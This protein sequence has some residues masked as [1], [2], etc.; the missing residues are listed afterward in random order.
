MQKKE[1]AKGQLADGD[2][3]PDVPFAI[4]FV[5]Q[6]PTEREVSGSWASTAV[7]EALKVLE[8]D[9]ILNLS[10]ESAEDLRTEGA[11]YAI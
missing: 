3:L 5:F 4:R 10:A 7:M 8:T 9:K 11:G 2:E 6:T 1:A